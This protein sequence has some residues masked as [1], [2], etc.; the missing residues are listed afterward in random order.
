MRRFL[1]LLL[2]ITACSTNDTDAV[3]DTVDDTDAPVDDTDP[4]TACAVTV[5]AAW[6]APAWDTEAAV[7]LAL[8]AQLDALTATAM[9]E[10]EQGTRVIDDLADLTAL[11]EAGDPS[12]AD[13][14]TPAYD[15]VVQDAFE[16]LIELLAAGPGDLV[17]DLGA[18]QPGTQGGVF[19]DSFRGM[20]EGGI[21]VRQI[22]DKG[23][24]TGGG[25]YAWAVGQTAG[26]ITPATVTAIAAAWGAD[27]DLAADGVVTDSANYT[28]QMGL[29]DS[30]ADPLRAARAYAAD[31]ACTAERDD[32]L[33]EAFQAWE[34]SMAARFIYYGVR[35][36][37]FLS[38]P[39]GDADIATALHELSEGV[40]LIGGFYGMTGPAAGPYTS[41]RLITDTQLTEVLT[42]VGV[43]LDDLGASTTGGFVSAPAALSAGLRDA[44]ATLAAAYGFTADQIAAFKLP[45]GD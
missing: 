12:V 23:L 19:S 35:A 44:E 22:A 28:F 25:L 10:A 45:T 4:T 16:E 1:L 36:E 39:G 9:R 13:V 41:G 43:N 32:A 40:G 26:E 8:R 27:R 33:R 21:E 15:A 20:N 5:P 30:V 7:A 17:D 34:R 24:F 2:P 42:A 3:D 31:A 14:A 11:Y 38:A 29:F 37:G 18:W 6:S